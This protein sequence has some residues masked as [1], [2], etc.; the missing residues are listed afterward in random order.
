MSAPAL[1]ILPAGAPAEI[2]FS[3]AA[4]G[5]IVTAENSVLRAL[6]VREPAFDFLF[7]EP[8]DRP[9]SGLDSVFQELESGILGLM[10]ELHRSETIQV[11]AAEAHLHLLLT[12]ALRCFHRTAPAEISNSASEPKRAARLVESFLRLV[13]AHHRRR[14]RL[15]EYASAL[16]VSSGHLR[17]SCVRIVGASPL[18]LIHECVIDEAKRRLAFTALSVSAIALDLGFDDPAYFS[19]LFHS[20]CGLSPTQYRVSLAQH[21]F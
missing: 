13:R 17:A 8:R 6:G 10:R 1:S 9:L 2:A 14:W 15:R 16:H 20:K 7:S 4:A 11:S 21:D 3:A 5:F 12:S 18:E 19:R